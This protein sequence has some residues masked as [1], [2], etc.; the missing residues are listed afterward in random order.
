[1]RINAVADLSL[2]FDIYD[3][4][5]DEANS[6]LHSLAPLLVRI[7]RRT[8]DDTECLDIGDAAD[9]AAGTG[10]AGQVENGDDVS[11]TAD[12]TALANNTAITFGTTPATSHAYYMLSGTA[13]DQAGNFATPES[14]TFV[15]DATPA[16]ATAPAAPAI[17]AGE[18]FQ[19]ASFLNDDL[20]IREYVTANFPDVGS[21]TPIRLG[22]GL[23]KMVDA[24]NADMLTHRN[25]SI[26][27]DVDTYAGLQENVAATDVLELATVGVAVRDQADSDGTN[28]ATNSA[29]LTVEAVDDPFEGTGTD[30]DN[31]T[32]AF[33]ASEG[34]LCVAEDMD[35]CDDNDP[36]TDDDETETELEVVVTA[37][38]DGALSDPFERVDFWMRDVN[39]AS[40]MLG[41][42]TS[43]ESGRVTNARTRTWTYSMEFPAAML[44]MMTREAAFPPTADSDTHTVLAFGVNDDGIALVSSVTLD[45]DDG[46]GD[47]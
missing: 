22:I 44:Y 28:D 47:Q 8:T 38:G 13:V 4:E 42:D 32:V 3:D 29:A 25:F 14:H 2:D 11:C 18:T 9:E 46:E 20:S 7:Q 31:F 10:T 12:P 36:A 27:A 15:F 24:F 1:M 23:P 19:I 40:W 39:G 41:S 6:G 34:R 43:G 45:I 30:P 21:I 33:T 17:E 37:G 26:T 35:D 5:N 16:T